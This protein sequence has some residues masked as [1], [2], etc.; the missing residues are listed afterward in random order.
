M[1]ME[2][3]KDILYDIHTT[4]PGDKYYNTM[5]QILLLKY[6]MLR[7]LITFYIKYGRAMIAALHFFRLFL[8]N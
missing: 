1:Y 4:N 8:L 7:Q 6:F 5:P 2:E 3:N